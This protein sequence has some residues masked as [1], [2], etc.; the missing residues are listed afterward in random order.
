MLKHIA[1]ATVSAAAVLL[2]S[3]CSAKGSF[4][5]QQTYDLTK[6]DFSQSKTWKKGKSCVGTILIFPSGI[7]NSIKYAA[8]EAQISK[9]VYTEREHNFFVPFYNENCVTVYGN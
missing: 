8:E 3:G 7:S 4:P 9:V 1:M 6:I 2:L 5:S